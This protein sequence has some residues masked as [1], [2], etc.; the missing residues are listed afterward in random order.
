MI[1][2]AMFLVVFMFFSLN[3][4]AVDNSNGF[5]EVIMIDCDVPTKEFLFGK[6]GSPSLFC[7]NDDKI[8]DKIQLILNQ[9]NKARRIKR[10]EIVP[11]AGGGSNSAS[12]PTV[13]FLLIIQYEK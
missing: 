11:V 2:V 12:S 4:W 9:K 5:F 6:P 8:A 7:F 1:K 13:R 10:S 3:V